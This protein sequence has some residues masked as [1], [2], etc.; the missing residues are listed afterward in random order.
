MRKASLSE[1][2]RGRV[3]SDE[4]RAKLSAAAKGKVVSDETKAKLSVIQKGKKVSEE[5][6]A[7]LEAIRASDE[8]RRKQSASHLGKKIPNEVKEKMRKSQAERR[9]KEADSGKVYVASTALMASIAERYACDHCNGLYSKMALARYHGDRCKLNPVNLIEEKR[10][11]EVKYDPTWESAIVWQSTVLRNKYLKWYEQI[12]VRAQHRVMPKGHYKEKHH[13]V[14]KSMLG[15]NN[16]TNLVNLTA[17]EHF[18]CHWLLVKFTV[19]KDKAKMI[20]ALMCITTMGQRKKHLDIDKRS[21]VYEQYKLEARKNHSL[22]MT[23][24]PKSEETRR[25]LSIANKGKIVSEESRKKMSLAQVGKKQ[26]PERAAKSAA[27][28][29]GHIVSPET[30]KKISEGNKG[31]VRSLETRKNISAAAKGRILSEDHKEKL[32]KPKPDGWKKVCSEAQK[33]KNADRLAA[34]GFI[35]PKK[36]CPWCLRDIGITA[37]N[38][39]HGDNCKLKNNVNNQ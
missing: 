2:L 6:K 38:R 12:V 11:F 31:K 9:K 3:F 34:Q 21:R 19:G 26:S 23:G 22:R 30:R 1:T 20:Y 36:M 33:N 27:A 29:I 18:L 5:T 35:Y 4:H 16:L 32:R 17:R 8:Y 25:K 24:L 15:S 28:R 37:Y 14:P 10:L 7:K 39:W 13:V